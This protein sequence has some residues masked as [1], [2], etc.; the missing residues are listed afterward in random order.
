MKRHL[1]LILMALV[2]GAM[3]FTSCGKEQYTITVGVNDPAMGS[4]TGGGKYAVNTEVTLT[5][6]ANTG[7]DF[8]AWNDGN[9]DNPRKVV[10]TGDATYTANFQ[11]HVVEGATVS[12]Q[13]N[14]WTAASISAVDFSSYG[15]LTFYLYKTAN[16]QNDIYLQGWLESTVGDYTYES[17]TSVNSEGQTIEGDY[18]H[19]YDAN[20][21][22]TDENGVIGQAGA[23][24]YY[25]Q[26][27]KNSFEEHITAV[28][29]NN[30]KMSAT[31]SEDIFSIEDYVAAGNTLPD[32]VYPLTCQMVNATW[33]WQSASKNAS[34][35]ANAS[36]LV[37]VK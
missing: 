15:Y 8:V 32:N 12:F 26:V 37:A 4:A 3:M 36:K 6:T 11:R 9:T 24:Y 33:T 19:Y 23:T 30:K 29:L 34:K 18:F 20:N 2:A 5:A 17:T 14:A 16:D 31:W 25:W 13:G 28:D 35:K 10:V 22:W 27:N 21:T 7:Y 1:S